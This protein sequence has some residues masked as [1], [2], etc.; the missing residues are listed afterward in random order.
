MFTGD[1]LVLVVISFIKM[2]TGHDWEDKGG[3][4]GNEWLG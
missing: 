3:G 2:F 1:R 4:G